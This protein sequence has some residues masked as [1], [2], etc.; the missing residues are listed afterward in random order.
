M[1]TSISFS[2]SFIA[3][4]PITPKQLGFV[5]SQRQFSFVFFNYFRRRFRDNN[6]INLHSDIS[7]FKYE[8]AYFMYVF[9]PVVLI[10]LFVIKFL[11]TRLKIVT[12]FTY[13][14]I[15]IYCKVFWFTNLFQL[16]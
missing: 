1:K 15:P 3:E 9:R 10:P 16:L 4:I 12:I 5:L 7:Q 13:N 6:Q 8:E 11:E 2:G 14:V